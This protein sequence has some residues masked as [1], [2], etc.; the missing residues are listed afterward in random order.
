M[1]YCFI[2]QKEINTTAFYQFIETSGRIKLYLEMEDNTSLIFA[3]K[4]NNTN[5]AKN[6]IE[7]GAN[8]NQLDFEGKSL[9]QWA[10]HK[11]NYN[12]FNIL[13]Q[14]NVNVDFT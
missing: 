12:I 13:V 6:L 2:F 11:E 3:I 4:S 8:V 14:N 10:L 5:W 9:L 1:K 7:K